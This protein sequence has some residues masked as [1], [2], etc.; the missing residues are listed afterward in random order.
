MASRN[1]FEG[2]CCFG[3]QQVVRWRELSSD[4]VALVRHSTT[5]YVV[6]VCEKLLR[7]YWVYRS[8]RMDK[9]C[10]ME[11]DYHGQRRTTC[12][13][14][15]EGVKPLDIH[16]QLSAVCGEKVPACSIVLNWI[17]ASNVTQ[18]LHRVVRQPPHR[19]YSCSHSRRSQRWII[20]EGNILSYQLFSIQPKDDKTASSKTSTN[21]FR[22]PLVNWKVEL[23]KERLAYQQ[24]IL[25]VS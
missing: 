25:Q 1:D 7:H 8:K 18:K 24:T 13:L 16:S 14:L 17:W 10:K 20:Y 2:G 21:H 5:K 9:I 23:W 19:M 3:K 12:F 15:K 11:G 22:T 6:H 4:S